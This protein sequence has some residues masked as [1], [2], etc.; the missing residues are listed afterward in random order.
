LAVSK[1]YL[2][3]AELGVGP[4]TRD[5]FYYDFALTRPLA[6]AD[7]EE[8]PEGATAE[9]ADQPLKLELI[10]G[11][12][13]GGA[14]RADAVAPPRVSGAYRRGDENGPPRAPLGPRERFAAFLV[15][16]FAG[17]FPRP[18][19]GAGSSMR[20][21]VRNSTTARNTVQAKIRKSCPSGRRLVAE[22]S[23]WTRK[24]D[25]WAPPPVTYV[26]KRFTGRTP[27]LL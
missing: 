13:A 4:P 12:V 18:A 5:G 24:G 22:R 20:A 25:P 26:T 15:E 19:S 11:I 3:G 16:H 14:I 23:T 8:L 10:R 9:F 6:P 27:K 7:L 1:I 21:S 17:A 2:S